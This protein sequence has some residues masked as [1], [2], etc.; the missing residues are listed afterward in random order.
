LIIQYQNTA[1]DL[2]EA[3]VV[4]ARDDSRDGRTSRLI[5]VAVMV[6]AI[7]VGSQNLIPELSQFERVQYAVNGFIAGITIIVLACAANVIVIVR[8]RAWRRLWLVLVNLAIAGLLFG[9]WKLLQLLPVGPSGSIPPLTVDTLIP[10]IPWITVSFVFLVLVVS[11]QI[12]SQRLLWKKNPMLQRPKTAEI[13]ATGITVN[14][15]NA[16]LE[17]QWAAFS[18]YRETKNLL[19]LFLGPATYLMIPK[20]AFVSA[21]ELNAMKALVALISP[22]KVV[23]FPIGQSRGTRPM[24]PPLPRAG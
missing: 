14:D 17:Y 15:E 3:L 24:P 19:V 2:R 20:R 12:Q 1:K 13:V 5:L 7:F 23:G 21:E 6:V 9:E 18:K 4:A 16:R 22:P 8:L 10:H 11:R